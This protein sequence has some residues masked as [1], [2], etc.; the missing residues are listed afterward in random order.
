MMT[1]PTV[2]QQT[3]H[4]GDI[5]V[6]RRAEQLVTV[7]G[8]DGSESAHRALDAATLLVSGREGTIEVVYAA[9][10]SAGAEMRGSAVTQAHKAFDSAGLESADTVRNRLAD[11]GCWHFHRRD[12][13][14]AH[15]LIAVA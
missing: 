12:G 15:Q 3:E 6:P 2:Q 13:L 8:F 7:V 9:H 5:P 11:V 14:I 4:V 10:L 1:S